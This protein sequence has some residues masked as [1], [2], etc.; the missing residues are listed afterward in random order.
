MKAYTAITITATVT[1]TLAE[2]EVKWLMG[3]MQNSFDD[4]DYPE[5]LADAEMRKQFFEVL[6]SSLNV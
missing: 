1:L 5:T 4:P 2:D 3:R 6:N